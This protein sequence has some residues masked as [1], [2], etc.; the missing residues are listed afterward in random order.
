MIFVIWIFI[1]WGLLGIHLR[2][3]IVLMSR[4]L[5]QGVRNEHLNFNCPLLVKSNMDPSI[6]SFLRALHNGWNVSTWSK[7][8]IPL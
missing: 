6:H 8:E 3:P 2:E 5:Y 7:N 4:F 1:R